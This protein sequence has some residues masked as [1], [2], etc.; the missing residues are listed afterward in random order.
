M[1]RLWILDRTLSKRKSKLELA[2]T[3]SPA[4]VFVDALRMAWSQDVTHRWIAFPKHNDGHGH[5]YFFFYFWFQIL[6]YGGFPQRSPG[7][8]DLL[9][10]I[11]AGRGS[12]LHQHDEC[13]QSSHM[14]AAFSCRN[15]SLET[16]QAKKKKKKKTPVQYLS[17]LY[18]EH[19]ARMRKFWGPEVFPYHSTHEPP[20]EM[21]AA[22]FR[23]D[24]F[25]LTNGRHQ[26][27]C[28]S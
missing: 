27:P 11:N 18:I 16:I 23:T 7:C 17:N 26:I 5:D 10:R 9:G 14:T 13:S 15:R 2:K 3:S 20:L 1:P 12:I 8:V 25:L 22:K 21:N 6:L 28:E 19:E 4:F 24:F